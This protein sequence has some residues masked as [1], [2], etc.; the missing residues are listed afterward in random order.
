MNKY[1]DK[2]CDYLKVMVNALRKLQSASGQELSPPF[3]F[4]D[5]SQ[6]AL[7]PSNIG[8]ALIPLV[9]YDIS[10]DVKINE[11]ANE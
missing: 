9:I 3:H 10:S 8:K 6:S 5:A 7:M 4:G 1:L 2:L 11:G